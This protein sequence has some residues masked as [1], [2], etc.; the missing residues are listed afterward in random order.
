MQAYISGVLQFCRIP[1]FHRY[2]IL[3]LHAPSWMVLSLIF[4]RV[5]LISVTGGLT[6]SFVYLLGNNILLVVAIYPLPFSLPAHTKDVVLFLFFFVVLYVLFV[7]LLVYWFSAY[8]S[9]DILFA[10][11]GKSTSTLSTIFLLFINNS[12]YGDSHMNI[13]SIIGL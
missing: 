11:L 4:V 5:P 1:H 3:S 2:R 8:S 7:S 9:L 6:T 13:S 12:Q 10:V